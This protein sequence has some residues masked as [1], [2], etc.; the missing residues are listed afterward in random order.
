MCLVMHPL[1]TSFYQR[2]S[3]ILVLMPY[4]CSVLYEFVRSIFG[5]PVCVYDIFVLGLKYLLIYFCVSLYDQLMWVAGSLVV[6]VL[7]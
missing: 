1:G 4:L 3:I 7:D 2:I 5:D 6:R